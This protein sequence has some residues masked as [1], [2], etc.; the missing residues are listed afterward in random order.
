ME[1]GKT[2][3][4]RKQIDG[5][6]TSICHAGVTWM[7]RQFSPAAWYHETVKSLFLSEVLSMYNFGLIPVIPPKKQS[8]LQLLKRSQEGCMGCRGGGGQSC[9][10]VRLTD[11]HGASC[12]L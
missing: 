4:Y 2:F 12:L 8:K 3:C 10:L 9:F 1:L 7:C 11:P 5:I 6:A